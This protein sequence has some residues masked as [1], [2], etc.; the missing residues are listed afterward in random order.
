MAD[1][2]AAVLGGEEDSRALLMGSDLPLLTPSHLEEALAALDTADV[3][4]GPSEDGGYYLVG[5]KQPHRRLFQ[6]GQWGGKSVLPETL[7]VAEK[8]GLRATRI[9]SLPDVDTLADLERVRAHPLFETLR[10]RRAV[11]LIREWGRKKPV[12]GAER[13][14]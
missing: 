14:V 3:V 5:M 9:S 2:L 13:T 1:A 7:K 8:E 6:P 12:S 11:S 4:F 10:G